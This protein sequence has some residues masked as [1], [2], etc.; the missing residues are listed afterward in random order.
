M[1]IAFINH[2]LCE[3]G[4]VIRVTSLSDGAVS[5]SPPIFIDNTLDNPYPQYLGHLI[6]ENSERQLLERR[7]EEESARCPEIDWESFT[8]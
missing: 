3:D 6:E 8:V 5:E 2:M 7:I 4:S 1:S